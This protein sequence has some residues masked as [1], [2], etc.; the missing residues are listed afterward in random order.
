[1]YVHTISPNIYRTLDES[2]DS[3]RLFE[4]FHY[5]R[6]TNQLFSQPAHVFDCYS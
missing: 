2:I 4:T 6:V 5:K 3:F 1:M